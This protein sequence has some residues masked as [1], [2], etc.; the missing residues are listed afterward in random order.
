MTA[1]LTTDLQE[2]LFSLDDTAADGG[3]PP[4]FRLH[5]LELLNWG[6]F[7]QG[8]RTFRLDGAN[9][10]LTGD[11]GSGKST[12]VDAI[13][14][15]LLPAHKIEYNKA[16]G[17]QKKE[18]SLL[19]YVRGFH[20]SARSAGGEYSK[21]VP[22]RATGQ[23]TVVLGVFHNAVL[24]KWITLGITLW[25]TQEAGQPNRFYSLAETDQSIAADFSNFGKDPLKLKKKLRA[26]GASV[27]DS[28]E[29]YS[30]AFKRQFGISG[31]QAMELFHRTVSMKQ[32][33]NI[34]SFVRSNM[35]EEDDVATRITNLIHHF[36]DLKKAHDAVLRAKDQIALLTPIKEGAALHAG[37]TADD[38]LARRQRDQLHPWFTD[39]KLQLSLEHQAELEQTGVRL[40]EDS[41]RLNGEVK[42]LRRDLAGVEEDIRT[43]GGG[44]LTAIDAELAALAAKS[45]EQKQRF[46]AYSAAAADLGLQAPEDRVLFDANRAGLVGVEQDLAARSEVLH[47]ERTTLSI[48]QAGLNTRFAEIKAELTSLQAR[49]NLIPLPQ[50]DIR[51]RLCEGTGITDS[52]LPYVGELLKV[53]DGEAAWEGA[54]ERTLHGFAL[55]LLVPAEHY[56]AVSSWVDAN[57]LRGRLVYLRVGDSYAPRAAEPGTLAAKIAIK[58]GTPFRDF[59]QDEL[60]SRFDYFCCENLADFRRYPKALTANGQ[61]KGRRGRHEK[62]DRKDLADRRTYVLGWDNHDKIAGFRADLDEVQGTLKVVAGLLDRVNRQLGAL[63]RHNQQLGVVGSV[64][65]FGEISWQA[66]ARSIEDLKAEKRAL[67]TTS[68]VLQQLMAKQTQVT[69]ALERLEEKTGKL[70]ERLGANEKD[71]RDIAEA[72]GECRAVLGEAPVTDDAGVLAAV[73]RLAEAA[74]GGKPLTYKNTATVESTVRNGLTDTIDALSKRIARAAESTVRQMADFRNRYPNETTDVDAALEAAADYNRLLEQL[75]GNDLPRFENQFKD[76]LNQNTIREVVAFNA[77]L[78]SRRQN[79]VDRIGEINQSLSSIPYNTGRHIQL[80]HQATSDQ[81]VREFGSDLRACSEGTIGETDQYSEQKYLQVERLIDRFRGREGL[82]DLDR[83]W[84]AKVTD[85][86]NW[87]TFSASEKWT[88]T[89]EEYEHFTDSGGKSGGQK[90]KLAY[91]ILAAA[92][93]F[94]FGLG[95][96]KGAGRNAGSGRS[97]RFVVIDEAFGRGSDESARYGLELFQR[98]KLQLLIVTPLQKIH[99]IEPFVS[100]VG[101]VANTNGDDSQLRNMTIQEYREEKDRRGQ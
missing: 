8:V 1:E 70:R 47:G 24:G 81:D 27:H 20:K 42:Q 66:T 12:V 60:S 39:R 57:N 87:F 10:L 31:N 28:F 67:E 88:E 50:L 22:L 71:A 59:L 64:A 43:N 40:Q 16:A 33:E 73:G 63:G 18:R 13:T 90:E 99:V 32:V 38:E 21:P 9:S 76:L 3:T 86:R 85:V 52:D 77:F 34:T 65:E 54:A 2:S 100:H 94:Q 4:G 74:L 35:L 72:I 25:A 92:L 56:A 75:V 26:A 17:A 49:R 51:R 83:K 53:R 45:A 5:R 6:T 44:R 46:E 95:S 69:D 78:D 23:L 48:Q 62:D 61:L 55:S 68:D 41:V 91:T 79:I 80:E 98:M 84:T 97:F 58:Q 14:T 36:D 19:S 82:T 89:G 11:I 7:H 30:A 101:F 15:L 93:A 29:P 37:L 96:G